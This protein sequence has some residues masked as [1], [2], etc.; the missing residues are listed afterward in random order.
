MLF[1]ATAPVPGLRR[2]QTL[3][4][5]AAGD[6]VYVVGRTADELGASAL[7]GMLGYVG[8][9]V[10]VSDLAASAATCRAVSRA[11]EAGCVASAA[12]VGRGG[13]GHCLA[14]MVMAAE[15]GLELDLD[16]LPA[17]AGLSS[18]ALLFSETTGRFVLTCAPERAAELEEALAGLEFARVGAVARHRRLEI[19]RGGR[20]VVELAAGRLR[21]AFTRRFG[22]L[23]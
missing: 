7:Y 22:R 9:N 4:P 8:R 2:V 10:P 11:L 23:V 20:R 17:Q 5:K 1:T 19:S 12:V 13:L 18:L 16:A 14:R 3:E 6:A 21:R 15:R